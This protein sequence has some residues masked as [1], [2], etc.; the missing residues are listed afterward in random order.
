[1][2]DRADVSGERGS[3]REAPASASAGGPP[4]RGAG[5]LLLF[6]GGLVVLAAVGVAVLS[7]VRGRREGAER[8]RLARAADLGP[9]V[10]VAPARRPD[11]L[12][13]VTLPGDVRPNWQSTLYAKVNGYVTEILAD[14]G[15]RVRRGQVLARISSPET[16]DQ[17]RS[18]AAALALK[19]RNQ[20]RVHKLAPSGYVS[21]A[22]IDQAETDLH[23]AQAE[24]QR[25][26]ALQE[27]E[28]L[29]APFD[30]LVTA[31]YV[32]PGALLTASST[33]A[34]VMDLADPQHVLVY[35]YVGQDSAPFV[36]VG[37]AGEVT[38]DQQPGL[39]L[40]GRVVRVADAIDPR[41]R[42]MLVEL[43][44]DDA[45]PGVRL[46]PGL[47]VHVEL[48][49]A[50]PA[51][52]AVPSDALVSRGDH[53]QVATVRDGRLHF[54]DVVPGDTDGRQLQIR[55]G[56]RAGE[57]V[58]LSPPSDLAE[59]AP[60]QPVSQPQRGQPAR[61]EG[62]ANAHRIAGQVSGNTGLGTR[63]E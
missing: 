12:R 22:D 40:P 15:D 11:G 41:S 9:R 37:D 38:L 36:R 57:L 44:L 20:E 48:H 29:R 25:V 47:F 16:D 2:N 30:G 1:M 49:V 32:D 50:S 54:V 10:L 58:A 31:R 13:T 39:R 24:Y 19:R 56:L 18:A 63:T 21:R 45:P 59:G 35:V 43:G 17:V 61:A 27:Y 46:V 14:R 5:W 52:P 8:A 51:L 6:L 28:V 23:A 42:S 7:A 33:G 34:P 53:L 4:R 26:R 3:E 55:E 60:I 62:P